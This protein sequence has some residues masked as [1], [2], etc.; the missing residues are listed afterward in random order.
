MFLFFYFISCLV[1]YMH[2]IEIDKRENEKRGFRSPVGSPERE[3]KKRRDKNMNNINTLTKKGANIM[4]FDNGVFC[5]VPCDRLEGVVW[6]VRKSDGEKIT[7]CRGYDDVMFCVAELMKQR[8][9]R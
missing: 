3:R 2:Y 8:L 1:R 6:I 9:A 7:F 4:D 5:T